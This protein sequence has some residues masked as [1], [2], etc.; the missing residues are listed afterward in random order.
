MTPEKRPG[1]I[2]IQPQAAEIIYTAKGTYSIIQVNAS[3]VEA[4]EHLVQSEREKGVRVSLPGAID[5]A[6]R[7]V[8]PF[9]RV[10]DISDGFLPVVVFLAV[11][12]DRKVESNFSSS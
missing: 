5:P 4:V 1:Y 10:D 7:E 12:C 2:S 11:D 9:E 8:T 3:S 6:A